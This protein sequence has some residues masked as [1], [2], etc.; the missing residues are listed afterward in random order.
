MECVSSQVTSTLLVHFVEFLPEF[1]KHNHHSLCWCNPH[2]PARGSSLTFILTKRGSRNAVLSDTG[3]APSNSKERFVP[4]CWKL[5]SCPRRL[6]SLLWWHMP[7]V[8]LVL[9]SLWT[10]SFVSEGFQTSTCTASS[11]AGLL[12]FSCKVGAVW[13]I[14]QMEARRSWF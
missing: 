7:L 12:T 1:Y 5:E 2:N 6:D 14:L 3:D 8:V 13:E 11:L 4:S 10:W 9:H